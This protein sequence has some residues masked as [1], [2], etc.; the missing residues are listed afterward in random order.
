MEYSVLFFD[1]DDTLYSNTNGLWEAI[2]ERMTD[3][4]EERLGFPPD[5]IPNLRRNYFEKYGTTL[6]GLQINH[7]VD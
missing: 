4:M 5:E 6:R 2:R 7:S 3:F 1:L